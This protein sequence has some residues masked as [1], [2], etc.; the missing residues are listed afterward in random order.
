M[1]KCEPVSDCS[2]VKPAEEAF[3]ALIT[4]GRSGAV[5]LRVVDASSNLVELLVERPIMFD[6]DPLASRQMP[7]DILS[8]G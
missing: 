5:A 1:D 3:G 2:G 6:F 7:L 4:S 8:A